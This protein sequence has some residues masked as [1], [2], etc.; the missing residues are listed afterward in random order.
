MNLI[1]KIERWGDAHHPKVL[2]VLRIFLGIFLLL[3]GLGFMENSAYLRSLIENRSDILVPE[4][5]LMAL[6]YYVTFV[7]MVGGALISMGILTRFWAIM[8]IPVVFGA[9]FFINELQSPFNTDLLSSVAALLL[10]FV[11]AIIG[12]GKLSLE[13]YLESINN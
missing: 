12:S 8:Q 2:D 1:H 9:V 4:G 13:N 3:K 7:H 11:F 5:L 6:V 10:L